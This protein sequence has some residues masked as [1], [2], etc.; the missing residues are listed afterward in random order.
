M[1]FLQ[2]LTTV[3][4]AKVAAALAGGP[5]VDITHVAVGSVLPATLAAM[6]AMVALGAEV[7]RGAV[8]SVDPV[9]GDLDHVR[10]EAVIPVVDG[11]WTIREAGAFDAA[12]DLILVAQMPETY[13]PDPGTDGAGSAVYVRLNVELANVTSALTLTVDATSVMATRAYV[14]DASVGS[15]LRMWEQFA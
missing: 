8:S 7:W 14:D 2:C 1:S 6:Q 5:A 12:G 10:I 13:K 9:P 15:V 3:G 4:L 11:G